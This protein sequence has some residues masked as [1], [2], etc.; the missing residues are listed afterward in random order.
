MLVVA[1]SVC[2][3]WGVLNFF[4]LCLARIGA[5]AVLT[6]LSFCKRLLSEPAQWGT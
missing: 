3:V 4:F 6:Q 5:N 1:L 2:L